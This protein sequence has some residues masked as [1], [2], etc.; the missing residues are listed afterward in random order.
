MTN[1]A[2]DAMDQS[3]RQVPRN[4]TFREVLRQELNGF[5]PRLLLAQ[6]LL[7]PLP[8]FV[9]GRIRTRVMRM[10]GFNIGRSTLMW[11]LPSINGTGDIYKN[12]RVGE[13]CRFNVGCFLE[14]GAEI[15]VEDLVGFGPEVMILTTTH[16]VGPSA[17]R[18]GAPRQLPVRIGEGAWVGARCTILP[19]VTIGP[20]AII[21]AGS[22]VNKDVPANTMVAGVPARVVKELPTSN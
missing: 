22:V 19:G 7:A 6:L 1:V 17:R 20:G 18:S 2:P 15:I 9:G 8:I 14:L 21:A 12:L 4:N 10:A 16:E 11:G 13:L 5:R 3:V